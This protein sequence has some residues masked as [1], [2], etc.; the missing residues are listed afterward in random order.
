MARDWTQ[1]KIF[2]TVKKLFWCETNSSMV[3]NLGRTI[4]EE[5]AYE[6]GGVEGSRATVHEKAPAYRVMNKRSR[7][8][9]EG[10]VT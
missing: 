7:D 2:L 5:T 8:W 10:G 6:N 9:N 1:Q 3:F 4:C